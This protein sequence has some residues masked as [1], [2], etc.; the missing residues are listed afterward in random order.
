MKK[1]RKERKGKE[2]CSNIRFFYLKPWKRFAGLIYCVRV[3]S[4]E[5]PC[6][7]SY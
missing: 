3:E 5:T 2:A 4:R 6:P 7:L 1:G